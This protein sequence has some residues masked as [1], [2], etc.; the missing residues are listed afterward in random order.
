MTRA[1]VLFVDGKVNDRVRFGRPVGERIIDRRCRVELY[2]PGSTFGYVQW[3]ADQF[4]TQL[5]RFWVLR[6]VK[7]GDR[8]ST[9]PGIAPG[10]DILLP[11]SGHSRVAR[12][13][14]L[15]DAIEASG[16]DPAEAPDDYWRMAGNRLAA[17]EPVRV[18]GTADLVA[19]RPE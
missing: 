17:G 14:A 11:L 1:T 15:V 8:A 4:G 5:W 9:V 7:P 19:L 12:A 16:S 10:A 13:L 3:R 18:F 6:A 2:A